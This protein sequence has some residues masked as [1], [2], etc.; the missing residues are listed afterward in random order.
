VGARSLIVL[1][2][3]LG[4]TAAAAIALLVGAAAAPAAADDVPPF[5]PWTTL[6]PGLAQGYE[7]SSADECRRGSI[8]CVDSVI[9][10][11]DRR[12]RPLARACDHDALFALTY[13]R[14]TEEYRRSAADGSFF[15]DTP[16]VNHQDAVFANLY[17]EAFDAWH[18]GDVAATPPAW[19]VAFDAADDG[20]VTGLGNILLG[21]AAHVNRDLPF[22]LAEIG[23]VRPDGSSRKGDH[24][25]VNEFLNRVIVPL[26]AEAATR[27]DSTVDDG[28][29]PFTTIDET[30]TMQLLVTW[31]ELAWRNAERLVAAPT[32]AARQQVAAEIEWSAAATSEVL[33][34]ATS[35][36][37]LD[38]LLGRRAARDAYCAANN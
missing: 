32:P 5:I 18:R 11:M 33:A 12:F 31:R 1:K 27:F 15:E 17:F 36:G 25:K 26:L 23:L 22:T 21:M 20:R 14:T 6:L 8:R 35:Y 29:L 24:D 10:E 9:R 37:P 3:G 19:R 2:R 7:P 38:W 28:N 4:R 30:L 13:L 34:A 16:F